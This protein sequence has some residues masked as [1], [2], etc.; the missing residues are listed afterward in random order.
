VPLR[1]AR[2]DVDEA[3]RA[4]PPEHDAT[5][6][7][8]HERGNFEQ[9][10]SKGIELRAS[11]HRRDRRDLASKS[12]EQPI[13]NRVQEEAEGVRDVRRVGKSIAGER[14]L[15]GLDSALCVAPTAGDALVDHEPEWSFAGNPFIRAASMQASVIAVC[16]GVAT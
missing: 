16:D 11:Q 14:A 9:A 10:Q 4:A 2:E 13:G 12:V 8:L 15:E 1:D 3:E 7:L 6:T 5:H